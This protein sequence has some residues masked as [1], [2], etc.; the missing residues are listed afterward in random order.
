MKR[1]PPQVTFLC[2]ENHKA[3]A[4]EPPNNSLDICLGSEYQ[5]KFFSLNINVESVPQMG[6]SSNFTLSTLY[7]NPR[8]K[9]NKVIFSLQKGN[10]LGTQSEMQNHTTEI[11]P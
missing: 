1:I 11:F 9:K 10:L 6:A 3:L 8:P 7:R 5:K 2:K 4:T